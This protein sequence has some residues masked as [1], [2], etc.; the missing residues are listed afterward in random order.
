MLKIPLDTA[1]GNDY[2]NV[3]GL[4]GGRVEGFSSPSCPAEPGKEMCDM[5]KPEAAAPF[6]SLTLDNIRDLRSGAILFLERVV[7]PAG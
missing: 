6:F 7:N 3:P 4:G 5:W 1:L 2:N